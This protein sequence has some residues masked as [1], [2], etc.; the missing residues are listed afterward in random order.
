MRRAGIG[1]GLP[2]P[3]P[4]QREKNMPTAGPASRMC[5]AGTAASRCG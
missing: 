4:A 2:G 3:D 1:S 5:P